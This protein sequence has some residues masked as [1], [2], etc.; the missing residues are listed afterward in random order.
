MGGMLVLDEL[1]AV[2]EVQAIDF[3]TIFYPSTNTSSAK[4]L[5]W[6]GICEEQSTD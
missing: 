4:A 3:F 5:S 6:Y 1:L 2:N